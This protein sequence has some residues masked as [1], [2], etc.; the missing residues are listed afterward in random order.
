MCCASFQDLSILSSCASL[1]YRSAAQISFEFL[2]V[3][4]VILHLFPTFMFLWFHSFVKE[5]IKFYLFLL[6]FSS[7]S[8]SKISGRDLLLVEESCN[9]PGPMLQKIPLLF[10]CHRVIHLFIAF[11]I[12]SFASSAYHCRSFSKI[13]IRS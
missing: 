3:S 4:H 10:R 6:L 8:H 9:S 13:C 5:A 7:P 1:S 12:A 2:L 11:I